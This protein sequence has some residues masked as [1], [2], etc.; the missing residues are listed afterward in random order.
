MILEKSWVGDYQS[1]RYLA[2]NSTLAENWLAGR[3]LGWTCHQPST[4]TVFS[5]VAIWRV[6]GGLGISCGGKN[7]LG[8]VEKSKIFELFLVNIRYF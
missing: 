6:S 5:I 4:S 7:F 3:I 8:R 2:E 1:I